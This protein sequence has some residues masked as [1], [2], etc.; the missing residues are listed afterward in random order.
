MCQTASDHR[1]CPEKIHQVWLNSVITDANN[2]EPEAMLLLGQLYQQGLGVKKNL[3]KSLGLLTQV[4]VLGEADVSSEIDAIQTEITAAKKSAKRS[5]LKV[6]SKPTVAKP[7]V[8]SQMV[9]PAAKPSQVIAKQQTKAAAVAEKNL[10]T[11]EKRL[12]AEKLRRYKKVMLQLKIEQQLID[13]QQAD[14]TGGA[15]AAVE[16]EF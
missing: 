6:A 11:D 9:K 8:K 13:Q 5:R 15:L 7:Q 10:A 16:D 14:V 12:R 3:N 4:S 2:R 1:T